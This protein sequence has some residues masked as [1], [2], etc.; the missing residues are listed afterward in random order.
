[1]AVGA[2]SPDI[3]RLVLR[4]GAA[5]AVTGIIIGA[6]AS[7]AVTR[8]I[9]GL[10]YGISPADPIAFIV[11]IVVLGAVSIVASWVPARRASLVDAMEVLR[12][13]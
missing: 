2:R 3:V 9:A 6:A 10:L 8:L 13:G 11:V 12:G 4:Q 1:V 5:L 7:L